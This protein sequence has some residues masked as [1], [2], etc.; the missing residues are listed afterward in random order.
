MHRHASEIWCQLQVGNAVTEGRH[1]VIGMSSS[2]LLGAAI[3]A[4]SNISRATDGALVCMS[5]L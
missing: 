4:F 2:Q 3:Y 5:L 1:I